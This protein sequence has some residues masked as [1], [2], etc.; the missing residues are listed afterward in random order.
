MGYFGGEQD[1]EFAGK[2]FPDK[3]ATREEVMQGLSAFDAMDV[4]D[5]YAHNTI[6]STTLMSHL[7]AAEIAKD[8]NR[9]FLRRNYLYKELLPGCTQMGLEV[10][11][12]IKEML[13][14]PQDSRVRFTSGGSESLYSAIASAKEWGKQEKN[15]LK[16]EIV[17][18]YSIHTAFSKWCKYASINIKRI[19]LGKD[20]RA[21]VAAIEKAITKN[22]I[23]IAGS[24]PCWPYGLFDDIP[25][26]GAVAEK[27]NVWMHVDGCLGGFQS[28]FVEKLGQQL[29][30][31]DF[32]VPGVRSISAD[33]HKHGYSAKPLSSIT[34][35]NKDWEQYYVC[36][37][38]DWPDGLYSTEA[39]AGTTSA[40]PI[41][42]AWAVM[43][44]L[45]E[46]GYL[47]LAKRS[48]EVKQRYLD[49]I[50]NIDG[51]ECFPSDLCTMTLRLE[52]GLDLF[53]VMGGLFE[54]H[55]YCL[56]SFQPPAL[57]IVL[58]PVTDEVVDTFVKDLAEVIPLVKSGEISID[59]LKPWM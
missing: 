27:H 31:W 58:D 25:A 39:I 45:G 8:A 20:Y 46:E 32:R 36:S 7:E 35:R 56:P 13:R 42:S 24:A 29:P 30:T 14:F 33:L 43:K 54:R 28:P 26:L 21:D 11:Q 55:S 38:S 4:T 50:S 59:N 40:G 17:V 5:I 47:E 57:K 15:I 16:P 18:P 41:A 48:M 2:V 19:P 9:M 52:K 53:A 44:F 23:L 1:I 22:T 51:V 37:A 34:F 10:K 49:K 6:Q 3:G 12:M